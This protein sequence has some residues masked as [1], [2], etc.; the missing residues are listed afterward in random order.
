MLDN[1]LS[2]LWQQ[3]LE[4]E[5]F[6]CAILVPSGGFGVLEGGVDGLGNGEVSPSRKMAGRRGVFASSFARGSFLVVD[7]AFVGGEEFS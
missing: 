2:V 1:A 5:L 4:A 7:L 3:A 6:S